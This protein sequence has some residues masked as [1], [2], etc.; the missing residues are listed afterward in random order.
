MTN[1]SEREL[2]H[3]LDSLDESAGDAERIV[4]ESTIVG[5]DWEPPT[6]DDVDMATGE[7]RTERHV[8]ELG[9]A[10]R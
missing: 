9:R 4:I 8:I 10:G 1:P 5:T 7:T 3:A 2:R 6:A